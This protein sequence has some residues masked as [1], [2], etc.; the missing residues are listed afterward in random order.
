MRRL[1]LIGSILGLSCVAFA[2]SGARAADQKDRLA[3]GA[4]MLAARQGY[5]GYCSGCHGVYGTG[6]AAGSDFTAPD[7]ISRLTRAGMIEDARSKH[8]PDL[9]AAWDEELG[10]SG[11]PRVID[12]IREALMIPAPV[13]DAS[14]GRAIYART[15][16]VCHGERG[17][18]ASWARNSLNPPPFDFTSDKAKELSR[19]HM[20]HTVTYGKEGTAMMPFT[21]QFDREQIAAVVDYIRAMFMGSAPAT[22]LSSSDHGAAATNQTVAVGGY[23]HGGHVM[24]VNAP[25]PIGLVGDAAPGRI[26]Y[27][28]NC[29]TCHG[30][31][32]DGNGPR[33]YFMRRKPRNF[34][35]P[36]ARAEL[37]RPRLFEGI[38]NGVRGTEMPAWSKVLTMQEVANV[39]EYVFQAFIDANTPEAVEHGRDDRAKAAEAAG[40]AGDQHAPAKKN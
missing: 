10:A 20:L 39:A 13:A 33:A 4:Q 22:S 32:G 9:V 26:F 14:A 34:T 21:T 17:N 1:L 37:D 2:S 15:C 16:S 40:P 11:L 31:K 35:S 8:A 23:D 30:L 25:F 7:A 36:R 6:G 29:R 19:Q 5:V 27:E 24:D 12:Y 3:T 28:E 38:A 18:A